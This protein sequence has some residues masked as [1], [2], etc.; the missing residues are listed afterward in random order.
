MNSDLDI[1]FRGVGSG[2][3]WT[4]PIIQNTYGTFFYSLGI[5]GENDRDYTN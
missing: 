3:G 2:N 5:M 4:D 1:N